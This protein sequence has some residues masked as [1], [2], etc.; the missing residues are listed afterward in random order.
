MP[1]PKIV[2]SDLSTDAKTYLGWL[3]VLQPEEETI[4]VSL[5]RTDLFFQANKATGTDI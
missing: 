2:Q 3:A 4:S 1:V 5:E